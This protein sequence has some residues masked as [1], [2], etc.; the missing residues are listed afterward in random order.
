MG[1]KS[2]KKKPLLH[3]MYNQKSFLAP[4]SILSMAAIHTKIK[5]DGIAIL[6]I[7]DCNRSVRI[8][9]DFNTKEGKIEM[10]KKLDTILDQVH[11]F[12]SEVLNR[13]S[14]E[15]LFLMDIQQPDFEK[16]TEV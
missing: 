3:V 10:I 15:V 1:K 5:E 8:W 11:H 9:N 13:C 7:S 2:K 6:R 14:K 16:L 12:R 4:N